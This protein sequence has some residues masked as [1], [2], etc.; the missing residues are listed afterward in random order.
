M[1]G[2]Y[3]HVLKSN[4]RDCSVN[5]KIHAAV[6]MIALISS[7]Q[8]DENPQS[9]GIA[10]SSLIGVFLLRA[11]GLGGMRWMDASLSIDSDGAACLRLELPRSKTDQYNK[12]H[13]ESLKGE[14]ILCARLEASPVV[15][16]ARKR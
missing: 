8:N 6:E 3:D 9:I 11:I 10:R 15:W 16:G 14:I 1:G 5:R 7:Q 2:R 12:W 13:V 4:R